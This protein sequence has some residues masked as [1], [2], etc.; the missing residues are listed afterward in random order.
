MPRRSTSTARPPCW[1]IRRKGPLRR[2]SRSPPVQ[3][4]PPVSESGLA[5]PPLQQEHARASRRPSLPRDPSRTLSFPSAPPRDGLSA[6][7]HDHGNRQEHRYVSL[8]TA[9]RGRDEEQDTQ[10]DLA[11]FIREPCRSVPTA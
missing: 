9:R 1:P 8:Q 11:R 7:A 5:P 6:R 3:K 10:R 4:R 2:A